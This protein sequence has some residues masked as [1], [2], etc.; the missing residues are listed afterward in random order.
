MSLFLIKLISTLFFKLI[1][2]SRPPLKSIPKF[3][4]FKIIKKSEI[5][6]KT[7]DVMK[8][9]SFTKKIDVW[10]FF[11]NSNKH[12]KVLT[13]SFYYLYKNNLLTAY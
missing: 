6:K 1:S 13:P 3:K 4:P 2:I 12:V 11:N 10:S 9:V 5:I 7:A 8:K